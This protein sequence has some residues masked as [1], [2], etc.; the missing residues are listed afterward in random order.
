[1]NVAFIKAI[2]EMLGKSKSDSNA[3]TAGTNSRNMR[4][5]ALRGKPL[6][7]EE[8][9]GKRAGDDAQSKISGGAQFQSSDGPGFKG[10]LN[11]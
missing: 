7:E 11:K 10:I 9:L 1:M 4:A 3:N 8:L 2:S 6:N 5:A